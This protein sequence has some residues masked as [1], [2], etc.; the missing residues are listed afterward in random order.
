M[1]WNTVGNNR[2]DLQFYNGEK[3]RKSDMTI[4]KIKKEK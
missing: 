3:S 4:R 2:P 1:N